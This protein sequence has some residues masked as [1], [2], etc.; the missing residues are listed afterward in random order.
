MEPQAQDTSLSLKGMPHPLR[1]SWGRSQEHPS[2]PV[3]ALPWTSDVASRKSLHFSEQPHPPPNGWRASEGVVARMKAFKKYES[4]L[5]DVTIN[6]YYHYLP[7]LLMSCYLRG[8]CHPG[9][10]LSPSRTCLCF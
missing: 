6:Y 2:D 4:S 8:I 7:Q 3:P 9:I 10:S 1:T 5:G